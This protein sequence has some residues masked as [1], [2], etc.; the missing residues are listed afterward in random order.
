MIRTLEEAIKHCEEKAIEQRI[1]ASHSV[2]FKEKCNECAFEHEQLAEWLMKLKRLESI[3]QHIMQFRYKDYLFTYTEDANGCRVHM[4]DLTS[5]QGSCVGDQFL[6]PHS[7]ETF[8][9]WCICWCVDHEAKNI[10][11]T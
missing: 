8:E 3:D 4:L 2:A 9:T 7:K 11:N 5:G 10:C 1:N 6:S